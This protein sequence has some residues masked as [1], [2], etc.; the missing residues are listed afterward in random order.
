METARTRTATLIGAEGHLVEVEADIAL[1]LPATI[2]TGLPDT[3]LREARDRMRA[4]IINSGERWPRTKINVALHPARL[5][6]RGSAYDL[7]YPGLCHT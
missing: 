6:K 2:L 1:G 7:P 5:P 3:V 4:A